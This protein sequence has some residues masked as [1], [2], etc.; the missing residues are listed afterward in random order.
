MIDV[1]PFVSFAVTILDSCVLNIDTY[2]KI[3]FRV[4]LKEKIY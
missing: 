2:D 4:I 3:P 1:L